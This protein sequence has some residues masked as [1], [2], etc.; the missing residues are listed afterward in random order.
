MIRAG[1]GEGR[2]SRHVSMTLQRE[3]VCERVR[4]FVCVCVSPSRHNGGEDAP[5]SIFVTYGFTDR[6]TPDETEMVCM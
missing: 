6:Q 5:F 3:C 4:A 2:S 1:E